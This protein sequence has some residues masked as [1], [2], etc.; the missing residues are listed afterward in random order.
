VKQLSI[1]FASLNFVTNS[2]IVICQ[3]F[4]DVLSLLI[5]LSMFTD[6]LTSTEFNGQEKT[7]ETEELRIDQPT[8]TTA[9]SI[10]TLVDTINMLKAI[11]NDKTSKKSW[12]IPIEEFVTKLI[13]DSYQESRTD[14]C[15]ERRCI[16]VLSTMK[17][18]SHLVGSAHS[19]KIQTENR[20][21]NCPFF[22]HIY[23]GS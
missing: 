8:D 10:I 14:N 4:F 17:G 23:H 18:V 6:I 13:D 12:Q 21:A 22:R 3:D 1:V 20:C 5:A 15:Q 7:D 2:S 19:Q 9:D 16:L 11:N